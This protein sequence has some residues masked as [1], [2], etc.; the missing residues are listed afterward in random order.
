MRLFPSLEPWFKAGIVTPT[1]GAG[2]DAPAEVVAVVVHAVLPPRGP[3]DHD[4]GRGRSSET[5][6]H[7]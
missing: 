5:Q 1:G 7:S 4:A 3:E 6:A 2:Q